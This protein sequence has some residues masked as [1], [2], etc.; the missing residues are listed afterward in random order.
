VIADVL[1]TPKHVLSIPITNKT[2][3][4]RST[5]VEIE[6]P[7]ITKITAANTTEIEPNTIW[8]ILNQGGVLITCI[9]SVLPVPQR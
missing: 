5:V 9:V 2:S 8:S 6:E 4:N 7:G 1:T 3:D